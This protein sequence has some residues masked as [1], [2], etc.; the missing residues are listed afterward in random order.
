VRRRFRRGGFVGPCRR[1]PTRDRV[2]VEVSSLAGAAF[3][4]TRA[5]SVNP[6]VVSWTPDGLPRLGRNHP[7]RSS[8]EAPASQLLLAQPLRPSPEREPTAGLGSSAG[9]Y[10]CWMLSC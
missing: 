5:L 6:L 2:A 1:G 3:S 10:F 7:R 9:V 8:L 4:V